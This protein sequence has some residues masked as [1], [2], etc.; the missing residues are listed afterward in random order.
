V[1][2]GKVGDVVDALN[3]IKIGEPIA[4]LKTMRLTKAAELVEARAHETLTYF[5]FQDE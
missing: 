5:P 4:K 2:K 3:A 1:P